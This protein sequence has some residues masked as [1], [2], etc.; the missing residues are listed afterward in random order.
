VSAKLITC[1]TTPAITLSG[2]VLVLASLLAAFALYA[3]PCLPMLAARID[4][5]AGGMPLG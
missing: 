5:G 4:A 2:L 3:V 1:L